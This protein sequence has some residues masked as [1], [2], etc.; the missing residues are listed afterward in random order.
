MTRHNLPVDNK[1]IVHGDLTERGGYT[2]A[3]RLLEVSDR[4]TAIMTGNDLMAFGAMRAIEER[5]LKVGD[6]I[7]V[8]GFDD[9]PLAELVHP[10]LTTLRQPIYEIGRRLASTLVHMLAGEEIPDRAILL[11]PELI[12]R[13]SSGVSRC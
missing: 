13:E 4:P 10:T 12:I 11:R 5:G 9:I 1:L 8:G 7:A 3:Q 6:D 2:A